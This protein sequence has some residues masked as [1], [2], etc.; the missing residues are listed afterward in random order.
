MVKTLEG[1][2]VVDFTLAGAGPACTKALAEYGAD[3][4]LVEPL[5]GVST[6][7]NRKYDF[8]HGYK[9][10]L[11]VNL[12]TQEGQEIM[13][14]LLEDADV[15]V[16][17]Y[18]MKALC[19]LN[20]DYETLS[21]KYP[22][23]IYAILTGYGEEGE[24]K[25]DPG[26]DITGFWAQSGLLHDIMNADDP[27]PIMAPSG[28]GDTDAGTTLAL[29]VVAALFHREKTGKGMKVSTS[30]LAQG[31]YVNN[32]QIIEAQYGYQYPMSRKKPDRALKNVYRCKDGGWIEMMTMNWEKDFW[33]VMRAI[34]REDL[35]GDPRWT[36][37]KDTED[38][39]APE[40]VKILDEGLGKLTT[41]EAC[42]R[43]KMY[44]IAHAKVVKS[45]D[46]L[47]DPQIAA[48]KYLVPNTC[49]DGKTIML[50][51]FPVRVGDNE[52]SEYIGAPRLGQHTEEILK[53][54]GYSQAEILHLIENK[55]VA[56]EIIG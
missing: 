38:E 56:A 34:G 19:N 54:H 9:R 55:I 12:K 6:R 29:G 42:S 46:T 7:V 27:M 10:S 13:A 30:L 40:V 50:P 4:I 11:P 43:L 26:F 3:D 5:T 1:I 51:A 37:M 49:V 41:E 16:T 48:N 39:K 8:Y 15:F 45:A 22:K 20:L 17:N 23:L 24:Q 28:M 21:R 14:R 2:K 53:E 32:G 36:C 18:R 31:L 25:D 33:N 44:G 35:V 52:P 47:T